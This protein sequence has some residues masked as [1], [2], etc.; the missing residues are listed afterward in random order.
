MNNVD[1]VLHDQVASYAAWVNSQLKKR[2]EVCLIQDLEHDMRNGIAFINIIKILC[3][4]IYDA[5]HRY[6]I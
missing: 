5:Y 4:W 6:I 3:R 2:S 1:A